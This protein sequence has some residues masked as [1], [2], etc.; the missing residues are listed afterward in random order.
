MLRSVAIAGLIITLLVGRVGL[1]AQ[2]D[3]R[4]N[5]LFSELKSAGTVG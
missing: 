2:D 4:L 1:A 3:S 5:D